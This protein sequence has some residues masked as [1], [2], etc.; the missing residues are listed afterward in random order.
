MLAVYC[1]ARRWSWHLLVH[2]GQKVFNLIVERNT[3]VSTS[4]PSFIAITINPSK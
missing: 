2:A 3:L 4:Y 1:S